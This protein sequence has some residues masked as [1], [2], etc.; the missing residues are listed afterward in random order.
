MV[1]MIEY[2][3]LYNAANTT[4]AYFIKGILENNGINTILF[5]E[6]LSIGVGELPVDVLQVEIKVDKKKYTEAVNIISDYEKKNNG[7]VNKN[8]NWKCVKCNSFNPFNF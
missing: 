6:D 4:E 5:G 8:N 2:R 1:K 3:H 7:Y